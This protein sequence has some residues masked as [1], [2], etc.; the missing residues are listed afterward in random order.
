[1]DITYIIVALI[2]AAIAAA[3]T[4]FLLKGKKEPHVT[5]Q[6]TPVGNQQENLIAVLTQQK[7][8]AEKLL[9]EANEKNKEL[10]HQ[11]KATAESGQVSPEMLSQLAETEKLKK[12][13]KQLEGEIEDYEDDLDDAKKKLKNK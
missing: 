12:K 10:S 7:E 11:L 5:K 2:A 3:I 13:I 8:K 4:Y 1:M 9:A 6:E